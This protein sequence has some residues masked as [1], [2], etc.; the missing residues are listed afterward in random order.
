[1]TK[2]YV[3]WALPDQ[4]KQHLLQLFPP[5]FSRL[6]AHHCTWQFGVTS[7]HALPTHQFGWVMGESVDPTGVQAL[8]LKIGGS[9]KRPDGGTLHITWSLA[10]GRKPVESNQAI[11]QFG[12]VYGDPVLIRLEPKFF[13][14]S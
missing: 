13:P 2:G 12:V 10:P 8:V 11:K 6:I 3:G 9:M 14:F 1:M 5:Q 7:D 4:A